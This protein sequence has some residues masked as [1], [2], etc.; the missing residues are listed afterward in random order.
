MRVIRFVAV[1]IIGWALAAG[2]GAA[3]QRIAGDFDL[4][5]TLEVCAACHGENGVPVEPDY[6]IIWGQEEYYLYVQLKDYKSGLRTNEIMQPIAEQFEREQMKE[7]AK[8][9]AGRP[10]PNLPVERDDEKASKGEVQTHAGEC[11]QCHNTYQGDSRLPRVAG[12]QEAYLRRTMIEYK[13]KVRVNDPSMSSLMR[14]YEDKGIEALAHY[15][16]TL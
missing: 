2:S 15:L 9:F 5:A 10:W 1:T 14:S 8:Y 11:A 4:E 12:Q 13:A 7:L 6:P 16:A 3:Q